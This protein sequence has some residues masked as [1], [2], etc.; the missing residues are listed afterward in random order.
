MKKRKNPQLFKSPSCLPG[1]A[2]WSLG[3]Q[4]IDLPEAKR[5]AAAE[6]LTIY[7]KTPESFEFRGLIYSA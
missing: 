7:K 6:S 1:D 4:A 3:K 2:T 5:R